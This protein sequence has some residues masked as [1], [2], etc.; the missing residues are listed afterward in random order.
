MSPPP[1][2]PPW[3]F[4]P[5]LWDLPNVIADRDGRYIVSHAPVECGPMLAAGP[6]LLAALERVVDLAPPESPAHEAAAA[7]IEAHHERVAITMV[8]WSPAPMRR[9]LR[10]VGEAV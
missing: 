1:F 2:L 6:T 10:V 8:E 7:A 4:H 3:A 5:R 9:G